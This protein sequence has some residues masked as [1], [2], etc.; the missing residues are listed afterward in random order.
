MMRMILFKI[1]KIPTLAFPFRINVPIA[2]NVT[3]SAKIVHLITAIVTVG[4][5]T[6]IMLRGASL[7]VIRA[8]DVAIE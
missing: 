1:L 6:V 4:S 8:T 3:V 7:V 5:I 2:V